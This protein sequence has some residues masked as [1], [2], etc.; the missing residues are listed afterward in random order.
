MALKDIGSDSPKPE[1]WAEF[2][3]EGVT[4]PVPTAEDLE[5]KA[6]C[7]KWF[8]KT[9]G[10]VI[11]KHLQD[12]IKNHNNW[13]IWY[14][15]DKRAQHSSPEK[16]LTSDHNP[17]EYVKAF[18]FMDLIFCGS[19][20]DALSMLSTVLNPSTARYRLMGSAQNMLKDMH[21]KNL[22]KWLEDGCYDFKHE[23][24]IACIR[25]GTIEDIK[26]LISE[27][28][29]NILENE[30]EALMDA[31][32]YRDLD[33]VKEVIELGANVFAQ[34]KKAVRHAEELQKFEIA[35]HLNHV[36]AEKLGKSSPVSAV[37]ATQTTWQ[38]MDDMTI[39]HTRPIPNKTGCIREYFD[40]KAERL[41]SVQED[42]K[43]IHP[44]FVENF[45]SIQGKA[46]IFEAAKEL[47]AQDGNPGEAYL[48]KKA[49]K[50]IPKPA[51]V[52]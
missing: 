6:K 41:R 14:I 45:D 24:L 28:D 29:V 33:F 13:R 42:E 37:N 4:I 17:P 43:G 19:N 36:I 46:A 22:I 12:A 40:F 18:K 30:N 2:I 47:K 25:K 5:W 50:V 16:I 23:T 11:R 15:L 7:D 8:E 3:Y 39:I 49:A 20:Q 27:W 52:S 48:E 34:N 10:K 51:S 9:K 38:K 21:P 32:E 44:L 26:K 35:K 1:K 31:I